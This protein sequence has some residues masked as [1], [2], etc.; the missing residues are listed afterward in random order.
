MVN[1][2]FSQVTVLIPTYNRK[3]QLKL[4]LRG[5]EQQTNQNFKVIIV[6]NAS[7]Y[8]IRELIDSFEENLRNRIELYIRPFNVGGSVNILECFSLCKTKWAWMLSDDDIVKLDSIESIYYW[9]DQ[10]PNC[11]C[12]NF[13]LCKMIGFEKKD[14]ITME[15]IDEF[16]DNYN[17]RYYY[18]GDLIFMSN[19]VYNMDVVPNYL[20]HAF[21]YVN[22]GLFMT[23]IYAKLLENNIPFICVNKKIVEYNSESPR[24][25]D[26]TG[27]MLGTRMLDDVKYS[28]DDNKRK[29][30]VKIQ[31]FNISLIY[32]LYFVCRG[33]KGNERLFFEKIYHGLYKNILPVFSS[34]FLQLIAL[35]TKFDVGYYFWRRFFCGWVEVRDEVIE[36]VKRSKYKEFMKK[37]VIKFGI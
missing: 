29:K 31:A 8:N 36:K 30:I 20:I 16:I 27:I 11:G 7:Q 25:W 34:L 4:V 1:D 23:I 32:E 3:K 21:K 37:M 14:Y 5:L 28:F 17:N 33:N 10:F 22:S 9:I 35:T 19:K 6:D 18:H 24:A 2:N 13:S 26:A 12:F 15:T